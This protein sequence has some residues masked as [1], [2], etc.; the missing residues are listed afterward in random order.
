[1]MISFERFRDKSVFL[2]C[3]SRKWIWNEMRCILPNSIRYCTYYSRTGGQNQRLNF[4][5]NFAKW[6]LDIKALHCTVKK[7]GSKSGNL[8]R[9]QFCKISFAF[10]SSKLTMDH[11]GLKN[12][13]CCIWN[14]FCSQCIWVFEDGMITEEKDLSVRRKPSNFFS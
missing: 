14:T 4:L 6:K 2:M 12:K 8:Y 3:Q 9:H 11:K 5:R 7:F 10:K 13:I 1:M